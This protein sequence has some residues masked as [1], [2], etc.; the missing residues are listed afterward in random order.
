MR[1]RVRENY[2]I[3][4]CKNQMILLQ[5]AQFSRSKSLRGKL[6]NFA[7]NLKVKQGTIFIKLQLL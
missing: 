1:E 5:I 2:V 4:K 6:F 7:L 3:L